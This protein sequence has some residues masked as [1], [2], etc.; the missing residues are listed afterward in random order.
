MKKYV[1]KLFIVTGLLAVSLPAFAEMLFLS[2]G[3]FIFIDAGWKGPLEANGWKGGLIVKV[4]QNYKVDAVVKPS[5]K[6][7]SVTWG[8]IANTSALDVGGRKLCNRVF[9]LKDS[10][11][12]DLVFRTKALAEGFIKE[13]K[14]Q[15]KKGTEE[16]SA[17]YAVDAVA[18]AVAVGYAV[19]T[20][21]V[22]E[23]RGQPVNTPIYD[24]YYL[25]ILPFQH[26]TEAELFCEIRRNVTDVA[27]SD[28]PEKK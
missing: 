7:L 15:R 19:Q 6:N 9:L 28:G 27:L 10:K 22:I 2:S 23:D 16:I 26:K 24:I 20:G 18:N 12:N 8:N 14:D 3:P 21:R 11:K 4:L 13:V 17:K 5:A 1:A 25:P